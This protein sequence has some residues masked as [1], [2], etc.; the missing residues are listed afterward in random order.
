LLPATTAERTNHLRLINAWFIHFVS[1]I[2]LFC[3]CVIFDSL[4]SPAFRFGLIDQT[5][6][7]DEV[8]KSLSKLWPWI[9]HGD[10]WIVI[11]CLFAAIE[12]VY[13]VIAWLSMAWAATFENAA[14]AFRHALR[15]S[16]VQS[17]HAVLC[18]CLL[19]FCMMTLQRAENLH[20]RENW[21][22]KNI[23]VNTPVPARP[24]GVTK[25]SPEWDAYNEA[26]KNHWRKYNS[27]RSNY[28]RIQPWYFRHQEETAFSL[29]T[30]FLIWLTWAHHRAATA[31]RPVKPPAHDDACEKC[32]YLLTGLDSTGLCPE[33]GLAIQDSLGNESRSG[34]PWSHRRQL[35]HIKAYA[36]TLKLSFHPTLLG[37]RIQVTG[38]NS[39]HR[40]FLLVT[41][42][43][44]VLA[45]VAL[46][47][48]DIS[49]DHERRS[50][51]RHFRRFPEFY[52]VTGGIWAGIIAAILTVIAAELSG[53]LRLGQRRPLRPAAVRSACY[54]SPIFVLLLI[55]CV[56][57][58]RHAPKLADWLRFDK[59]SWSWQTHQWIRLLFQ[60]TPVFF[61]VIIFAAM[62]YLTVKA[63]RFANS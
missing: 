55:V 15:R 30:L 49:L 26:V 37:R 9:I 6:F 19:I 43:M 59:D 58:I 34:T 17:S 63:A 61:A 4:D 53:F 24:Q 27:A 46:A 25:P 44:F 11:T 14:Q 40:V 54:L 62:L 22:Q 23:L 56:A 5:S 10:G 45:A 35:S 47:Y 3:A 32:G 39:H 8:Q 29:T 21:A 48:L 51:I 2:C 1:L 36:Q 28:Q 38:S 33:C 42:A 52:A 57:S 12:L 20:R 13:L 41:I 18:F 31:D 50:P 7:A 60:L 16:W